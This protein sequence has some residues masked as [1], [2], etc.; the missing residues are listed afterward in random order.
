[1][2]VV[3]TGKK[4]VLS[5]VDVVF[6]REEVIFIKME[7]IL[8]RMGVVFPWLTCMW[9][10]QLCLLGSRVTEILLSLLKT[11]W[12]T[13]R[14]EGEEEESTRTHDTCRENKDGG[15]GGEGG[16]VGGGREGGFKLS[17]GGCQVGCAGDKSNRKGGS[18]V[19]SFHFQ[20]SL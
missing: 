11:N 18:K 10:D 7:V 16:G 12:P 5:K 6:S 4:V 20:Q 2:E 3:F 17:F 14:R 9:S 13:E 8:F 15:G 19:S 1:M